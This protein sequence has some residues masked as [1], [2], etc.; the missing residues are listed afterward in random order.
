MPIEATL[1]SQTKELIEK[2]DTISI[3]T[4]INPD[5]D[6]IATAL[7]VYTLLK[8]HTTKRLE[9][10]NVNKDLPRHLDFLE[11]FNKFKHKIEFENSLIISCDCANIDR[12]GI[13]ITKREIL[14]IDHHQDNEYYGN[15]N[16][17]MPQYASA[18]L[19]A[20]ELFKTLYPI[21]KQSATAF[22][23]ALLSDTRYFT[24]D[25]VNA[26]V[27]IKANELLSFGVDAK[28]VAL[29]ITQR[30]SLASLRILQRVLNSLE[31]YNNAQI[32]YTQA[33]QKDIKACGATM[34]DMD[35]IVDYGKS[36]SCVEISIFVI[37]LEDSYRVSLR[38]K[39]IDISKL[40][41]V[42]G[43]GG[44]KVACGFSINKTNLNDIKDK[45]LKQ[46]YEIGLLNG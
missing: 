40:A 30:R 8:K 10:I 17:I 27:F 13:D 23:T 29:N 45:I 16:I 1:I 4:H 18:S 14:N 2:Y 31:L 20:Y 34:P 33:T 24:T 37:E 46:I 39:N 5:A 26:D 11:Y 41:Q 7:G 6:T 19:V 9:I 28:I 21:C 25:S 3:L 42:F 43:G 38:S 44:H 36:L 12:I 35:G 15:I 22:Y 32:A